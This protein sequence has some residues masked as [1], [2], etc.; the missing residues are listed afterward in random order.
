M[1]KTTVESG[2]PQMKIWR[3]RIAHWIPKATKT[4]T[5]THRTIICNTYCFPTATLV[6]RTRLVLLSTSVCLEALSGFFLSGLP[7]KS[8][9]SPPRTPQALPIFYFTLSP[10]NYLNNSHAV[11]NKWLTCIS[12]LSQ[13]CFIQCI[14]LSLHT[15]CNSYISDNKIE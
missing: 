8:V 10:D 4:H 14:N 6:T 3:M 11:R 5:H 2:T 1:W 7:Y 13:Y 12:Y 15:V 9:C